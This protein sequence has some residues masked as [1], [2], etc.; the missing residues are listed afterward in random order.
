MP[1]AP[2]R[3][4]H[5]GCTELIRGRKYC[6][7]HTETWEG[8]EWTRPAN[9]RAVRLEVLERDGYRC[10]VCG[11]LGA[12]TVHHPEMLSRGGSSRPEDLVAIHDRQPPHCHRTVTNQQRAIR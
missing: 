1:R 6:P 12:D 9:W 8:S 4:P 11:G 5:A 2:R 7:A 3:C 10:R